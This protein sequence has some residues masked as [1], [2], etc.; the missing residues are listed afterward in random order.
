MQMVNHLYWVL[1]LPALMPLHNLLQSVI[2]FQCQIS[3]ELLPT[4]PLRCSYPTA[5][6]LVATSSTSTG[7][8]SLVYIAV[9]FNQWCFTPSMSLATLNPDITADATSWSPFNVSIMISVFLP[10]APHL[11]LMLPLKKQPW[12]LFSS[13]ENVEISLLVSAWETLIGTTHILMIFVAVFAEAD[14]TFIFAKLVFTVSLSTSLL[15][16]AAPPAFLIWVHTY[17]IQLDAS[18][19]K[20]C[21]LSFSC[22]CWQYAML[23]LVG[24]NHSIIFFFSVSCFFHQLARC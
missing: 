17:A 8:S 2:Q 21:R 16:P 18:L 13:T 12:L 10:L 6:P 22:K 4:S 3:L 23:I 11:S 1:L 24:S 19:Y 20:F 15:L 7:C 9:N 5:L 14:F